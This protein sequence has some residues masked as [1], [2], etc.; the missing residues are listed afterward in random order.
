LAH[1]PKSHETSRQNFRNLVSAGICCR[2]AS[3]A[4]PSHS[5]RHV[6][7]V[8]HTCT[9]NYT[10]MYLQLYIHVSI[11]N[12][13]REVW[14]HSSMR[15]QFQRFGVIKT[16]LSDKNLRFSL[17]TLRIFSYLCI[18]NGNCY[19]DTAW[20]G[21]LPLPRLSVALG[22]HVLL[23]VQPAQGLQKGAGCFYGRGI[24]CCCF[25]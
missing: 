7:F 20:M 17:I 1:V 3:L 24:A 13:A 8:I 2:V 21:H 15:H 16:C 25:A 9:F 14:Q 4:M 23:Q 6:A 11:N 5:T 22:R 18:K 10:Y 12:P 19:D